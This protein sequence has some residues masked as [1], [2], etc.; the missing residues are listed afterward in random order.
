MSAVRALLAAASVA[1]I[2]AVC[3]SAA[4]LGPETARPWLLL[5]GVAAV[6]TAVQTVAADERDLPAALILSLP[7]I[8][9]LLADGSPAWLVGPLSALLL[10]AGELNALSWRAA[11]QGPLTAVNRRRL[12]AIISLASMGIA[13]GLVVTLATRLPVLNGIPA[14]ATGAATLIGIGLI[15]FPSAR[16]ILRR[17]DS[18]AV[19]KS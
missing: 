7:S 14:I 17:A 15:V 1:I 6:V 16:I 19:L 8:A 3:F 10:A 5:C 2:G 9:S 12:K 11:A 4:L 18:G 13:A